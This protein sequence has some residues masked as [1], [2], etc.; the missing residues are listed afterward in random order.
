MKA[1]SR[2]DRQVSASNARLTAISPKA[3]D[4]AY[5]NLVQHWAFRT[6]SGETA[7]GECGHKFHHKGKSS[8]V[9]CPECGR[10]LK[11][12]DTLK[13]K[14]EESTYFSTLETIDGL[15]VQRVSLLSVTYKKGKPKSVASVEICRLWLNANG[16]TT[17]TSKN[18][19]LGHYLDSFNW[20]SPIELKSGISETHVIISN[21]YI[22]PRLTLIPE[23]RR[24]GMGIER[25]RTK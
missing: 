8:F 15:Q 7:C 3:I 11:I 6:P 5:R 4:W 18:R 17:G 2:F 23:L 19:T 20:A 25:N 1:K 21:T 14:I 9:K 12:K 22:Y 10:L 13:R 24:N 16:L